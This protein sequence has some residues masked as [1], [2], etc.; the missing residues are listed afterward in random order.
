MST[1]S[2]LPAINISLKMDDLRWLAS[3]GLEKLEETPIKGAP[4]G[5]SAIAALLEKTPAGAIA[6]RL[7]ALSKETH[8]AM[9]A[10]WD[11]VTSL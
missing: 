4:E 2:T 1:P 6:I 10:A 5:M 3:A 7:T 9:K 11:A 8:D